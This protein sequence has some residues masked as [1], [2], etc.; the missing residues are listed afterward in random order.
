M[1]R[2]RSVVVKI[3]TYVS[4]LILSTC[5]VLVILA[6]NNGSSAVISEVERALTLQALEASKYLESIIDKRLTALEII[7]AR[8]E[9][10]QMD[11]DIQSTVLTAELGASLVFT[12]LRL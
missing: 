10:Q 11:W 1:T 6:F 2:R 8:P 3:A 4:G 12:N 7:A 5:I 9:I